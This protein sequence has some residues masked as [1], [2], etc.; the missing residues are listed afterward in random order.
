MIAPP[1]AW[2]KKRLVVEAVVAKREVVVAEVPVAFVNIR[3]GK[4][5][6]SVVVAVK[7]LATTSPTT[8]SAAYGEV[9]PIPI[10]PDR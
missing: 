3:F 2:V 9:V 4:V 8:E 7:F 10:F 1:L 6:S 5:L